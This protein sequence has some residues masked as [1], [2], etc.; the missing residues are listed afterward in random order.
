MASVRLS[1]TRMKGMMPLVWPLPFT[2][3]PIERTPPQ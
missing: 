1:I 3:S 2:F